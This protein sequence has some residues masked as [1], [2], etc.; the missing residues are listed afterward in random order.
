M[1]SESKSSAFWKYS[2]NGGERENVVN[3]SVVGG[4]EPIFMSLKVIK[5]I[6]FECC[7]F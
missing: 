7:E 6:C 1:D 4:M 3:G 2:V 5:S